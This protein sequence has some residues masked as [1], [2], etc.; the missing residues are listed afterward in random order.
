MPA[1]VWPSYAGGMNAAA[2]CPRNRREDE[3]ALLVNG[4][5]RSGWAAHRPP[6][7]RQQIGWLS[8]TA[9]RAFERGVFQGAGVYDSPRGPRLL[10][11]FDGWLMAYDPAAATMRRLGTRPFSRHSPHV[12]FA[13]RGIHAVA[14]DGVSAPVVITGDTA[15]QGTH[16]T[17]GVPTGCMMAEGHGRLVV[18][19]PCRTRLYIGNH[20]ADPNADALEFTEDT[21]Y[22]K[23]TRFFAIPRSMGRIMAIAFAPALNGDADL[24]PLMVLCERAVRAFD[25][26]IPREQWAEVDISTT[27][28]PTIGACSSHAVITRGNDVLFSDHEG[29]IQSVR[30]AVAR[31]EDARVLPIDRAVWPLYAGEHKTH[32]DRRWA[33]RF[34]DRCLVTVQPLRVA[35]DNGRWSVCHQGLAVLQEEPAGP[36][37]PVWDGL[38][39]G[40]LP[41]CLL[42]T[43]D[44]AFAVSLDSD[45]F[46]RLYEIGTGSGHDEGAAPRR[47]P[48]LA[49]L[50]GRDLG[51]PFQIKPFDGLAFRLGNVSGRASLRGWWQNDRATPK[52]WFRAEDAAADCLTTTTDG[53]LIDPLPQSRARITPP[54]PPEATFFEAAP[55]LEIA[56]LADLQEVAL[57]TGEPKP[58]PNK[59]NTT[60]DLPLS[61][62]AAADCPPNPWEY[63]LSAPAVA[64]QAL[65]A[66]PGL[67]STL[68]LPLI[69][70]GPPGRDGRD[71]LPG[72]QGLKGEP[73]RDGED[74]SGSG[75]SSFAELDGAP[76]DNA[77]LAAAL[78]DKAD[79]A[80]LDGVSFEVVGSFLHLT[81]DGT[82]KRIRLL[83]L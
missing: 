6:F 36:L 21:A 65:A 68:H 39:T 60:C 78:E 67:P 11:A 19:S 24:G 80:A 77:A 5:V 79:A 16:P 46:H 34:D 25:I 20:E 62:I 15:E 22:Y 17:R 18:V 82:T 76:G 47:I 58:A 83:D 73:G 55:W 33:L 9:Q 14:Q 50:G 31:N 4:T 53:T 27:P 1:Y 54:S 51:Q 61:A 35:R 70:A 3:L 13:Q 40:I 74:G 28:L 43:T 64:P 23:N 63:D 12:W 26:S 81:K 75:A 38:W 52:P 2:D 57:E 59:R 56:G 32:L 8:Q 44:R 41:V 29:R 42:R 45:G 69:V 37:F 71:G 30:M 10:F 66:L 48:M 72:P 49:A 7:K